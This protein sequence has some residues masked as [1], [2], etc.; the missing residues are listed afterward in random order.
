MHY[1]REYVITI[2]KIIK[3]KSWKNK[4]HQKNVINFKIK[5]HR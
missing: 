2:K 1:V 5:I 3:N 4:S